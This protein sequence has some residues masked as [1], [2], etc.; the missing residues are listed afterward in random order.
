MPLLKSSNL[1]FKSFSPFSTL[2]EILSIL[3]SSPLIARKSLVVLASGSWTRTLN[4]KTQTITI[5]RNIKPSQICCHPNFGGTVLA[6][7]VLAVAGHNRA[8]V[9][10]TVFRISCALVLLSLLL[11]IECSIVSFLS[12]ARRRWL[13]LHS[14]S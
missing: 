4:R 1:S 7:G 8:F 12:T 2:L 5:H 6:W 9:G 10:I 11:R 3:I 13:F 14:N